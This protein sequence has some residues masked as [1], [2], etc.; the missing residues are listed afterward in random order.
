MQGLNQDPNHNWA[1]IITETVVGTTSIP[2][3]H[4][5]LQAS[6]DARADGSKQTTFLHSTDGNPLS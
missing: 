6:I 1:T 3:G 4:V 5:S 2:K